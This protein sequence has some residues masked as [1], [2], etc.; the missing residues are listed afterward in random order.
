MPSCAYTYPPPTVPRELRTPTPT[1]P[2]HACAW[3]GF[4]SRMLCVYIDSFIAPKPLTLP[5]AHGAKA[6]CPPS[7]CDGDSDIHSKEELERGRGPSAFL[8][9]AEP[10]VQTYADCSAR[11]QHMTCS[12][13]D[14]GRAKYNSGHSRPFGIPDRA[15]PSDRPVALPRSEPSPTPGRGEQEGRWHI[16]SVY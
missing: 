4:L 1:V 11:E 7:G 3:G 14:P 12:G 5:S 9:E 15:A 6:V 8:A 13:Q 2:G 16:I 10:L